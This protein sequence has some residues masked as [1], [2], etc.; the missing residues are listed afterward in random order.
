MGCR[1]HRVGTASLLL[2]LA[3]YRLS[4]P[5]QGGSHLCRVPYSVPG[6]V[7]GPFHPGPNSFVTQKLLPSLFNKRENEGQD[8]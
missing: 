1:L 5:A 6:L 8:G 2:I 7:P 4:P 3:D